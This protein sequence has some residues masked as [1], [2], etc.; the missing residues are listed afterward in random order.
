MTGGPRVRVLVVD[1]DRV[2]QALA[3][4]VLTADARFSVA[5]TTGTVRETLLVLSGGGVDVVLLDHDLPDGDA[6]AVVR[7]L[8]TDCDADSVVPVLLHTAR[9][10]ARIVAAELGIPFRSKGDWA[11]LLTELARLGARTC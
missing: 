11:G 5:G 10:D 8:R 4:A 7:G 2:V 9:D 1:D 6:A 3:Q